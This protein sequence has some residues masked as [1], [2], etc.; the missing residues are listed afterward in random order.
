MQGVLDETKLQLRLEAGSLQR[1]FRGE[2][3]NEGV[4]NPLWFFRASSASN[5]ADPL[6]LVLRMAN[7]HPF[8]RNKTRHEVRMMEAARKAGIQGVLCGTFFVNCPY[9]LQW[10]KLCTLPTNC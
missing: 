7:P 3:G 10:R 9:L 4:I 1:S 8:W 6:Q 5:E 2:G